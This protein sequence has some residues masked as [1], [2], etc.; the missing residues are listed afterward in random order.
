MLCVGAGSFWSHLAQADELANPNEPVELWGYEGRTGPSN[1]GRLKDEYI[2]CSQ[3]RQQSPLNIDGEVSAVLPRIALNWKKSAGQVLNNGH[4]IQI[5]MP[6]GSTMKRGSDRFE[7]LQIHFHAPSEHQIRA[8]AMPMEVHFV[9]RNLTTRGLGV[10]AVFLVAG[11]RN[12]TFAQLANIFPPEV[13]MA[14][15]CVLDPARLVPESLDYWLYEGSLT[16]PP[17]SE[18]VDWMIAQTPL[19]VARA[20]I[21]KFTAIYAM[22]ARPIRMPNRRFILSSS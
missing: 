16:T 20:D 18:D 19:E 11:R 2:S 5:N 6:A 21:A 14:T 22:N 17:C 7:L 12:E 9:H 10:L 8:Q 4:T 3:G 15:S 1:W 13:G